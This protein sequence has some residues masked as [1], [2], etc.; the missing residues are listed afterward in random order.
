MN[1]YLDNHILDSLLTCDTGGTNKQK[2]LIR[3]AA[4][5]LGTSLKPLQLVVERRTLTLEI[6]LNQINQITE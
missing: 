2:R 1:K 4:Y 3:K 5:V 6:I